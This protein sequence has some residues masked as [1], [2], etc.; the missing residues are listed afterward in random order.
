MATGMARQGFQK[1]VREGREA[2]SPQRR[3]TG[4]KTRAPPAV[5][6]QQRCLPPSDRG[7]PV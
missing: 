7:A 5:G 1:V 3:C 2:V 4:R 6:R